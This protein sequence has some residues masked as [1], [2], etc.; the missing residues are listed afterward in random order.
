MALGTSRVRAVWLA[1]LSALAVT[2]AAARARATPD[3]PDTVRKFYALPAVVDP[4]NGCQVCHVDDNGGGPTTL[5]PFGQ[6]LSQQ[7]LV[8]PYDETSLTSALGEL[9]SQQPLV[10][11]DLMNGRDPN[12]D[13]GVTST[14]LADGAVAST[15]ASPLDPTPSYGC[16][17]AAADLRG[18]GPPLGVASACAATL[19]LLARRGKRRSAAPRGA[20]RARALV[21]AMGGTAAGSAAC[22]LGDSSPAPCDSMFVDGAAD[23][24]PAGAMPEAGDAAQTSDARDA[25]AAPD[26]GTP[27][28]VS[29]L[30]LANWSPGAP[31]VDFCVAAHG[32]GAFRGPWLAAK[33]G[34]EG[35]VVGLAFPQVSTYSFVSPG[36]YDV[37]LVVAGAPDCSA[38]IVTDATSLPTLAAGDFLTIAAV[39]AA[40]AAGAALPQLELAGFKDDGVFVMPAS[41]AGASSASDGGDAASAAG[42]GAPDASAVDGGGPDAGGGVPDSGGAVASGGGAAATTVAVRFIHAAPAL[43]AVDFG[44]GAVGA[45]F[46]AIF[47]GVAFAH[48]SSK[49]AGAS[50]D[51]NGYAFVAPL[52][53]K[54]L[55]AELHGGA[56]ASAAIAHGVSAVAGSVLTFALVAAGSQSGAGQF[57]ECV[58]NAGMTG[59]VA[60]PA[61]GGGSCVLLQ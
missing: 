36:Q 20:A 17:T 23:A 54:T 43:G 31:E 35:G 30:R 37:R 8:N 47:S 33:A 50:A 12:G 19:L 49:D 27:V 1:A 28:T 34:G 55:S 51:P 48:A 56:D 6:L 18:G 15:G 45:G 46:K 3:F 38:G 52:S 16:S 40:S 60:G 24:T 59:L 25:G 5:R 21:L 13:V 41:G 58:D 11:S 9:A 39:G 53:N 32:S 42:G 57:V 29:A 14:T 4:P 26:S 2:T 22:E 7:Y 61:S 44:T 10:A